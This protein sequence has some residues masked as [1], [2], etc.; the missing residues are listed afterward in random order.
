MKKY[1]QLFL[2]LISLTL[3]MGMCGC[4]KKNDN[5][6]DDVAS[7]L[8]EQYNDT[9]SLVSAGNELWTEEYSEIVY[10]SKKLNSEIVAR[11]YPN[12]AIID[13]YIAVKYKTDVEQLVAPITEDVYGE[14][15]VVNVPIHYGQ[16]HFN[17]DLS[18]S[19]YIAN[20][21]S[22]ISIAIA[23]Y[24][25]SENAREDIE[26]LILKFKENRVIANIRVFYYTEN[27]F[28]KIKVTNEATTIFSPLSDKRLSATMNGDYSIGIVDWSE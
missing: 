19:D 2:L 9:F 10:T 26:K 21:Q 24:D 28:K 22:N 5:T 14:T 4:T 23:T 6:I 8:S 27:E 12:G 1:K 15:L 17:K 3:I 16:K 18:F 13:N 7:Y 25:N 20:K 11:V